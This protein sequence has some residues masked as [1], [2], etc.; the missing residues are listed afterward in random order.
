MS[1]NLEIPTTDRL[2]LGP[3]N[4][5]KTPEEFL[6]NF[7]LA[8]IPKDP[9][10]YIMHDVKERIIYVGKAK[11][12]R[13]RVRTYINEQDSRYS[14]KFLMRR[15]ASI[16]F[17]VTVNEKEALLLENSLIKQFKPRY[18]VQLKDD[19][20]YV[21]LRLDV[22]EDFPRL[23]VVRRHG[24]DGAKYFGPYSSAKS[25]RETTRQIQRM[26]PLRTCTDSVMNNR[27]R[28]CLYYQM[29][30]CAAPCVDYVDRE[31]YHE[32]VEQVS[33][34]LEGRNNELE[35]RLVAQI[36]AHADTQ[37]YEQAAT[38]RDRLYALR[39]TLERQRTVAV[40]G[41][42]D[43][44]VFGAFHD[45]R[46][47]EIQ[48]LFFRGGKMVGGRSFT[49]KQ[50]EMPVD[51]LLSSFLVQFYSEAPVIPR[52][53]LVPLPLEDGPVIAEILA[54]QRGTKVDVMHPRRG[55]K[56]A[57]IEMANRNAKS[58]FHEKQLAGQAK[59]DLLEQVQRKLKL[60]NV[61]GRIECFDI[62]NFQ[63]PVSGVDVGTHT[64]IEIDGMSVASIDLRLSP[65][66]SNR[67][68]T[69]AQDVHADLAEG[70]HPYLGDGCFKYYIAFHSR[71][72]MHVKRAIPPLEVKLRC[73]CLDFR[74][75]AVGHS[76]VGS[77]WEFHFEDAAIVGPQRIP[78]EHERID[79]S[80]TPTAIRC[81]LQQ[82]P[83][84]RVTHP[85]VNRLCDGR[86]LTGGKNRSEDS[87]ENGRDYNSGVLKV[88]H[89]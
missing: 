64:P 72:T 35:K 83:L 88:L 68:R 59:T 86:F 41:A 23:T 8:R 7:D 10:C 5:R 1:P 76:Q 74:L 62:S 67:R 39:R 27:V 77:C 81:A 69:I 45:G 61:P 82:R 57:L 4:A 36:K 34:V 48:I 13:S 55:E 31:A 53:I 12:L 63:G 70:P 52:E 18:N 20:T 89:A 40:P 44:D 6:E 9:G 84:V 29:N 85:S 58:S 49:F 56:A 50:R 79:R 78:G 32:I 80:I 28:P 54:E 14:V 71:D 43:R 66:G 47:S 24:K 16:D 21:S 2:E 38:V 87:R 65:P 46:Y 60:R 51:E 30:Q 25:V 17:L 3:G 73:H 37:E 33:M 26:F 19:K 42:A 22:K 11:N 15:V 75:A